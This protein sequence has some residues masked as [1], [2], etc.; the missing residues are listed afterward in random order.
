MSV[1]AKLQSQNQKTRKFKIYKPDTEL[2]L[3]NHM[4]PISRLY[5]ERGDLDVEFS[6]CISIKYDLY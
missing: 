2:V 4:R 1:G 6:Q 5:H 3:E